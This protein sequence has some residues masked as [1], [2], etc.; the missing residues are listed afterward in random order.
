MH[1]SATEV[2][3]TDKTITSNFGPSGARALSKAFG[4]NITCDQMAMMLIPNG[5]KSLS[6]FVWMKEI[7]KL[8]GDVQPNKD[9]VHLEAMG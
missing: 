9:E 8:I 1:T 7:F 3:F 6:A 4:M 2:P 5:A